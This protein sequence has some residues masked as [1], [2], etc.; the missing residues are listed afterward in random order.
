MTRVILVPFVLSLLIAC[1]GEVEEATPRE[2]EQGERDSLVNGIRAKSYQALRSAVPDDAFQGGDGESAPADQSIAVATFFLSMQANELA[3]YELARINPDELSAGLRKEYQV[4]RGL[5][6]FG[7]D[8]PILAEEEFRAAL[9]VKGESAPTER[10]LDAAAM[11]HYGLAA[12]SL[13]KQDSDKAK[14]HLKAAETKG[15]E[16]ALS[17]SLKAIREA[18]DGERDRAAERWMRFMKEGEVPDEITTADLDFGAAIARDVIQ[19]K[20]LAVIVVV[21]CAAVF[22]SESEVLK[23]LREKIKPWCKTVIEKLGMSSNR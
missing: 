6:Y 9:E 19:G 1:G 2:K 7:S 11:A 23:P 12:V 20:E 15:Q 17:E 3:L 16:P 18:Q 4:L 21:Y 10:G 14:E 5:A 8:W 13:R 22:I